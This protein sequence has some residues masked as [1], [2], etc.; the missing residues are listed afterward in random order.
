MRP[1]LRG[2]EVDGGVDD[3]PSRLR[4]LEVVV[5]STGP[6]GG[7]ARMPQTNPA[8]AKPSTQPSSASG[9]ACSRASGSSVG[10]PTTVPLRRGNL[11]NAPIDMENVTMC[12]GRRTRVTFSIYVAQNVTRAGRR[13]GV[14]TFRML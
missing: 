12:L 11:R 10:D 6:L 5:S 7:A 4:R 14:V 3:D 1:H 13:S 2:L 9:A 8:L